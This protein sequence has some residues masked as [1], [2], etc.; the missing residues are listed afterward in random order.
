MEQSQII[1]ILQEFGYPVKIMGNYIQTAA[2]F[3]GG[4]DKTSVCIYPLDNLV[5]DFVEGSKYSIRGLLSKIM[6]IEDSKIDS[7]LK[8]KNITINNIVQKPKIKTQ[9]VFSEDCLHN[10][11]PIYDYFKGRG[12]DANII[13]KFEG[14]LCL[15]EGK[16]KNR[17]VFIIRN[18]ENNI[19]GFSARDITNKSENKYKILGDRSKFVYNPKLSLSS[20]KQNKQ[21]ILVEGIPDLMKLSACGIDN[22]LCIFGTDINFATINFLLKLNLERIII[23]TNNEPD[24]KNIGNNAA[25]KIQKKLRKYWDFRVPE[26]CLPFSK[27]FGEMDSNSILEYKKKYKI[28]A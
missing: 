21:V 27:D 23:A 6:G 19:V 22:A 4:N 12:F 20:I 2:L 14:G 9:K 17:Y 13:K 16:L 7:F 8:T 11:L 1:S 28:N 24:N 10:L 26:I 5:V 25:E 18:S 15:K 3:R